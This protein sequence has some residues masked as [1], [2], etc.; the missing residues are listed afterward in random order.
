MMIGSKPSILLRK[1]PPPVWDDLCTF[2]CHEI[3]F[4]DPTQAPLLSDEWLTPA[5]I[6]LNEAKRRTM[7]LRQGRKLVWQDLNSKESRDDF[8]YQAP[9]PEL[10]APT[11]EQPS[12]AP[13]ELRPREHPT[14]LP[15]T[16]ARDIPIIPAEFPRE[17]LP[18]EPPPREPQQPHPRELPATRSRKPPERLNVDPKLKTY[19]PSSLVATVIDQYCGG[20]TPPFR[21]S[22][23]IPSARI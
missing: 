1:P 8:N 12:A 15:S 23:S 17:P 14:P 9:N 18:R 22:S 7:Q 4:D 16:W 11:R 2:Q 20:L 3:F 5:E 10:D 13:R 6:K 19:A 21:A